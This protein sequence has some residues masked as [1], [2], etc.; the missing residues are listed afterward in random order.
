MECLSQMTLNLVTREW[1]NE[2]GVLGPNFILLQFLNFII[3]IIVCRRNQ[4]KN[5]L[6]LSPF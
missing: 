1:D 4:F 2:G 6:V 3:F 5:K